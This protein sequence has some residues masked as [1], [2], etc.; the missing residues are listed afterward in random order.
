MIRQ[1]KQQ[2]DTRKRS[3]HLSEEN[4]GDRKSKIT[5]S[6]EQTNEEVVCQSGT[7]MA[8]KET[9]ENFA[10][11]LSYNEQSKISDYDCNDDSDPT[12]KVYRYKH[13]ILVK[14]HLILYVF[15]IKL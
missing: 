6:A 5:D 9:C 11:A 13:I 8:A 10:C 12:Y 14:K 15:V 3:T 4:N 1:K 7:T 2:I